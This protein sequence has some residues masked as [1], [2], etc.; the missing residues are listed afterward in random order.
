[1]YIFHE[2]VKSEMNSCEILTH[3][4]I[5]SDV[6]DNPGKWQIVQLMSTYD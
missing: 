4:L 6:A 5:T 2:N 3:M 1:M